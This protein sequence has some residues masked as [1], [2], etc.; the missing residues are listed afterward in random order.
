MPSIARRTRRVKVNRGRIVT[1][2]LTP[3]T[4]ATTNTFLFVLARNATDNF[5]IRVPIKAVRE[6][7]GLPRDHYLESKVLDVDPET[8]DYTYKGQYP[9]FLTNGRSEPEGDEE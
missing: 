7:L 9:R 4:L 3:H 6:L 8:T 2:S 5:A 1:R